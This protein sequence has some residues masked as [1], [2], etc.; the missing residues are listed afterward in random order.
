[1][2]GGPFFVCDE[3]TATACPHRG[4]EHT[5][6][7]D[8]CRTRARSIECCRGCGASHRNFIEALRCELAC[9]V[10]RSFDEE[11]GGDLIEICVRLPPSMRTSAWRMIRS[12]VIERD[13]RRCRVCGKDLSAVPSWLTEVHHVRPKAQ[14]GSDHP[15]NL[16]TLCVM[17][18]KRIT[19]ETLLSD[20]IQPSII[21]DYLPRDCLETLR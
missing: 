14:G 18:H 21:E 6:H 2:E 8:V 7:L 1:M 11:D 4:W 19:V 20:V 10:R 3:P 9:S 12:G 16:I 15:S 5:T 17:C 13:G